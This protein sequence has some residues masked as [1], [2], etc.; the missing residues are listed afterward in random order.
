MKLIIVTNENQEPPPFSINENGDLIYS[1]G[2]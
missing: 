1:T 2:A